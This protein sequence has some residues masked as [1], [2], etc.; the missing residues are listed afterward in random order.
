M[1]PEICAKLAGALQLTQLPLMSLAARKLGWHTELSRLSP[2]NQRLFAAIGVGIVVYVMG[3][4]VLVIT[5]AHAVTTTELG[6]ALCLLQA[7]AWT[8]RV[9][10]QWFRIRALIPHEARPFSRVATGVY[11]SLALLYG[12]LCAWLFLALPTPG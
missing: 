4:G 11:A 1:T 7:V 9:S 10:Q 12:L 2:V 5:Y 6:K 8:A 3:S